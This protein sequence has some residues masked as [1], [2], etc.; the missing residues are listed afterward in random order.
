V[1]SSVRGCTLVCQRTAS[2]AITAPSTMAMPVRR[3]VN[4]SR[5]D[6][7]IGFITSGTV[8][9]D[10]SLSGY[11]KG[12]QRSGGRSGAPGMVRTCDLLVRSQKQALS[13]MTPRGVFKDLQAR[14]CSRFAIASCQSS[15]KISYSRGPR[16]IP[17][18]DIEPSPGH[19]LCESKTMATRRSRAAA[20]N[21]HLCRRQKAA[22]GEIPVV[23]LDNKLRFDRRELDRLIDQAKREGV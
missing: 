15:Y 19:S 14:D 20:P 21:G 22:T 5:S 2:P 9:A 8:T 16:T 18:R 13:H 3:A 23:R 11:C 12:T 4:L 17:T 7:T 6:D 10:R 1:A